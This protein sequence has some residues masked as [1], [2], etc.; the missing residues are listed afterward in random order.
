[1]TTTGQTTGFT[2]L[3]RSLHEVDPEVDSILEREIQRQEK[4]L[5]LIPSENYTSRSVLHLRL[6]VPDHLA[7]DVFSRVIYGARLSPPVSPEEEPGAAAATQPKP[8]LT[9]NEL[10]AARELK[11]ALIR[12]E[13]LRAR[14]LV[15]PD[16]ASGDST[17]VVC[18]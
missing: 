11:A 1:M 7:R 8:E 12:A 16:G 6:H 5:V 3:S 13:G 4:T 14:I 15:V 17:R 18:D 2:A 10:E 9:A